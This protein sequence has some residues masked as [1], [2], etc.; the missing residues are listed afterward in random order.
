M[1]YRH[2]VFGADIFF[3]I[4]HI[5]IATSR[6]RGIECATF[7]YLTILYG[8]GD[9]DTATTGAAN[10]TW[11][12]ATAQNITTRIFSVQIC[13]EA[14]DLI[15]WWRRW[16]LQL[17][18]AITIIR[19]SGDIDVSLHAVF[20]FTLLTNIKRSNTRIYLTNRHV[21]RIIKE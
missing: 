6:E 7:Y 11:T 2:A 9:A 13:P 18:V 4:W 21:Q 10:F 17:A 3:F 20:V 1:Y 12:I 8:G 16:R 15:F 5:N 19:F 14:K